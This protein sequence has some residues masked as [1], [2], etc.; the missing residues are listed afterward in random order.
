MQILLRESVIGLRWVILA[1]VAAALLILT[2]C[3]FTGERK[4]F[5]RGKVLLFG[6]ILS[7]NKAA[8]TAWCLSLS[9]LLIVLI[10]AC[11]P[12]ETDLIP[13]IIIGLETLAMLILTGDLKTWSMQLVSFAAVYA[14]LLLQGLFYRYYAEVESQR[15]YQLI[16][17]FLGVFAGLVAVQQTLS[18]HEQLIRGSNPEM[19]AGLKAGSRKNRKK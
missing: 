9:R 2:V 5:S 11:M 7:M 6:S 17:I 13:G 3:S 8:R 4:L 15:V 16:Y 10:Y 12:G 14:I 1:H 18:G 19:A